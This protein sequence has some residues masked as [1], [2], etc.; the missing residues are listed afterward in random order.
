LGTGADVKEL[1]V[2]DGGEVA[3]AI[4]EEEEGAFG[5]SNGWAERESRED[6]R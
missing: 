3:V 4:V 6:V 2:A 5:D 1:V